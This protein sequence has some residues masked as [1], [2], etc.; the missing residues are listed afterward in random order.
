MQ[1]L[2]HMLSRDN[3]DI[4]YVRKVIQYATDTYNID[5]S[6]IFAVGTALG[7][8]FVNMV[9]YPCLASTHS[10]HD[11]NKHAYAGQPNSF[12]NLRALLVLHDRDIFGPG[13]CNT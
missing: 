11:H 10:S 4:E 6:R 12:A 9:T 8:D 5:T 13:N 1:E 2:K 3:P 7:G